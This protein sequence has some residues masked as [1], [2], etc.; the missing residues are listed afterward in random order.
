MRYVRIALLLSAFVL[1]TSPAARADAGK[2]PAKSGVLSMALLRVTG[3]EGVTAKEAA[4]IEEVLLTALDRT[5]RFKMIGRSDI[6]ALLD[7]ES[8]KQMVGCDENAACMTEIAAALGVDL[9]ATADI[10]H[11]GSVNV[12]TLKVIDVKRATVIARGQQTLTGDS[13]VVAAANALAAEVSAAVGMP[14]AAPS[15]AIRGVAVTAMIVG[16]VALAVGGGLGLSVRSKTTDLR[17]NARSGQEAQDLI[18]TINSTG[19]IAN[20]LLIGGGAVAGVGLTLR[21]VF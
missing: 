1:L 20:A 3:G 17:S 5:G 15:R 18:N 9:V 16:A 7:L 11:L 14:V 12:M 4:T 2:A 10:G 8:R 6:A 21:V 19:K 13:A